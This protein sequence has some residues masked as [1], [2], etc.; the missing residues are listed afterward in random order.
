MELRR[1]RSPKGK[2]VGGPAVVYLFF[3][4]APTSPRDGLR[5]R[6][7]DA[8]YSHKPRTANAFL[9]GGREDVSTGV[10]KNEGIG[11]FHYAVQFYRVPSEKPAQ[12]P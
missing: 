12:N 10:D 6:L 1:I 5:W 11:R 7:Q 8:V 9:V 3:E 4:Q 2:P